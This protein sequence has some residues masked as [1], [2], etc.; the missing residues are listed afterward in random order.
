MDILGFHQ[1]HQRGIVGM[2]QYQAVDNMLLVLFIALMV[3]FIGQTI[4]E[5]HGVE[6]LSHHL[7]HQQQV[8][9]HQCQYRV[10][11]NMLLLLL[12]VIVVVKFIGQL[13]RDK[14]GLYQILE[15]IFGRLSLFQAMDNMPLLAIV[16]F[17]PKLKVTYI[18]HPIPI[19]Q[20]PM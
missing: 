13:I 7:V 5:K 20:Q 4:M 16:T 19:R 3:E 12:V 10:L 2:Y 9:G 15:Q 17:L 11:D 6:Q 8:F 1:I 18:T 14:H